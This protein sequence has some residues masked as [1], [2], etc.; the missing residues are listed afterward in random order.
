MNIRPTTQA[1]VNARRFEKMGDAKAA[2][3]AKPVKSGLLLRRTDEND[4]QN[5]GEAVALLRRVKQ[6]IKNAKA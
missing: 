5:E 6:S 2:S 4:N 3:Q 1:I